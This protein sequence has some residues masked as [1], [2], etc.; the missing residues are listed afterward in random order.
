M[1]FA[2]EPCY[3]TSMGCGL[4]MILYLEPME[5]WGA[6]MSDPKPFLSDQ[7]AVALFGSQGA[8]PE[9]L[10]MLQAPEGGAVQ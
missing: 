1:R 7:A 6:M 4:Q 10:R 8:I 9:A 2:K 5:V 3:T